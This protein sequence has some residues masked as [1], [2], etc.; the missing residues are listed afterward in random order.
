M[1]LNVKAE[2]NTRDRLLEAAISV[3]ATEG[4][5]AIRVDRVAELAGFTKPVLYHYF[6]DREA[7]IAAA[8]AERFRR[9]LEVGLEAVIEDASR[10]TTC[11][12]YVEVTL[13][14]LK[15]LLGPD[16]AERRKFRIE[17]LGSAASR[18]SL[19]ANVVS[20]NRIPAGRFADHLRIAE[21]RGW[22]RPEVD[23]HDLAQWWI[24]VLLSRHLFEIDPERFSLASWDAITESVLRSMFITD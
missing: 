24:G 3:L 23:V 8:Q 7:L 16:G 15:T 10:T 22:L 20:S 6:A 4:E 9:T 1:S 11:E 5:V 12:E 13:V 14:W 2:L 21:S 19:L 18:P 17:V